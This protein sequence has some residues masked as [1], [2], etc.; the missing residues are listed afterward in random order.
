MSK[1]RDVLKDLNPTRRVN[2]VDID[3]DPLEEGSAAGLL[4]ESMYLDSAAIY[5]ENDFPY[6]I[7]VGESF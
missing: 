7:V 3:F 4:C 2:I 6:L 1:V 5:I